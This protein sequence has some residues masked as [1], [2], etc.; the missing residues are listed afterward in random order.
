MAFDDVFWAT[1][2]LVLVVSVVAAIM[3]A[4]Q[5]DKCLRLLHDFH[6][7]LLS[8]DGA[9]AW[10]DLA[11]TSSGVELLFDDA[12]RTRRWITKSSALFFPEDLVNCLGIWR[13]VHA[14]DEKEREARERQI[15]RT[16]QPGRIQRFRRWLRMLMNSL[17]DALQRSVV[18]LATTLGR[19]GAIGA[20]IQSQ[21]ASIEELGGTIRGV[22]G[23][24]YE[25]LLERHIGR[26]V[27]L[28]VKNPEGAGTTSTELPGYLVEYTQQYLA[29][30]NVSQDPAEVFQIVVE[31]DGSSHSALEIKA[32]PDEVVLRSKCRDPL[33]VRSVTSAAGTSDLSVVLVYGAQLPLRRTPHD[34]LEIVVERVPTIDVVCPRATARVRFGSDAT[35]QR[36]DWAGRAPVVDLRRRS[37]SVRAQ[38]IRPKRFFQSY[39]D[40]AHVE[41]C[42]VTD[43][44]G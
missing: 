10:G 1:I 15:R 20:A 36:S 4:R 18:V 14:L 22:V 40:G 38:A 41:S 8:K 37:S 34:R 11:V 24:S 17:S 12:R 3:R 13:T 9:V 32:N 25:P 7:T 5:T 27:V 35:A 6:V 29:V 16:F 23:R 42:A 28:E 19:A 30:F 2:L 43:S 44:Q 33:V 26:P 21:K 39:A 31:D